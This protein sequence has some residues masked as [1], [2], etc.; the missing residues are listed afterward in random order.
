MAGSVAPIPTEW[1]PVNTAGIDN[2]Q[3]FAP[4]RSAVGGTAEDRVPVPQLEMDFEAPL[5]DPPSYGRPEQSIS[6]DTETFVGADRAV[7]PAD[8]HDPAFAGGR[9]GVAVD[10]DNVV[11][12]QVLGWPTAVEKRADCRHNIRAPLDRRC[13]DAAIPDYSIRGEY[14]VESSPVSV[15]ERISV[16][17]HHVGDGVLIGFHWPTSLLSC[18]IGHAR[19]VSSGESPPNQRSRSTETMSRRY[20]DRPTRGARAPPCRGEG[21]PRRGETSNRRGCDRG[22]FHSPVAVLAP[23]AAPAKAESVRSTGNAGITG[24]ERLSGRW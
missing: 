13:V 17:V 1:A 6:V 10:I 16:Q 23:D 9:R 15:V 12:Q 11:A 7:P 20:R 8:M 19:M 5:D 3:L 2:F 24:S 14:L 4:C 18:G 22:F 21:P